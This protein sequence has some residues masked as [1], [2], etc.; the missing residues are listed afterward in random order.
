[1]LPLSK[2]VCAIYVTTHTEEN[3]NLVTCD[4]LC[5]SSSP[6]IAIRLAILY[7]SFDFVFF[8]NSI[9]RSLNL[10]SLLLTKMATYE[11]EEL[12]PCVH[13]IT[14]LA[15]EPM[16]AF[17]AIGGYENMPLVP[18]E[19]AIEPLVEL[20]PAV[21]DHASAAKEQ[22]K[23]PAD[24]LTV[25]ES[26]SIMLY[27]MSWRPLEQCLYNALNTTL[28]SENRKQLEP[29]FLYLK[30]LFTAL[31]RLPS[32]HRT[33]YRG[34]KSDVHKDYTRGKSVV[35]WGFSSCT[36]KLDVLQ[37][38]TFLGKTETRTMF[39]I[40]CKSGKDIRK[41]SVFP[42][43]DEV[44]I[45]AATQFKIVACLDQGHGLHIIQLEETTSSSPLRQPALVPIP[46]NNSFL[47]RR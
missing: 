9:F 45:L 19:I 24:G 42:A 1:M 12:D 17:L 40:E 18:L 25:D 32:I 16:Q 38:E 4:L 46:N 37:L 21:E 29:W 41:H 5:H 31:E 7:F 14:D 30:L 8:R 15:E 11:R 13:C 34:I 22:C 39:T 47:G 20:L 6:S 23:N 35:W 28:R 33:V 2:S 44:L 27:T 36:T 43:E 10:K 26:A 3:S